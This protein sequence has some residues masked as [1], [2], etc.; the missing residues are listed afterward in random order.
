MSNKEV[1]AMAEVQPQDSAFRADSKQTAWAMGILLPIALVGLI[2]LAFWQL[3]S[4]QLFLPQ[5]LEAS[6]PLNSLK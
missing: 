6:S 3:T 1:L 2:A 4:G 5:G